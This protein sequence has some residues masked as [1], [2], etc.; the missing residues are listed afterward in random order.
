LKQL[1]DPTSDLLDYL[2]SRRQI[3]YERPEV[4]L[5]SRSNDVQEANREEVRR[6]FEADPAGLRAFWQWP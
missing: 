4:S 3:A 2:V 1:L 6:R 5:P